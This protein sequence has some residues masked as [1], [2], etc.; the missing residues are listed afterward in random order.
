MDG[1]IT[2]LSLLLFTFGPVVVH[3]AAVQVV[4]RLR[5]R[6]PRR[7]RHDSDD[8][9]GDHWARLCA[10]T[11]WAGSTSTAASASP[12]A[13]Q[14]PEAGGDSGGCEHARRPRLTRCPAATGP[15][16]TRAL[17]RGSFNTEFTAPSTRCAI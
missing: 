4:A 11:G 6:A 1:T 7:V 13:M 3:R 5:G 16:F 12:A 17:S 10:P 2:L 9:T 15:A 8:L 14:A